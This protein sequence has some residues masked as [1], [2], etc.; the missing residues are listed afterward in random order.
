MK[1]IDTNQFVRNLKSFEATVVLFNAAGIIANYETGLSY[2]TINA[3]LTG[4]SLA[5][6]IDACHEADI[7]VIARTDFSKVRQAVYEA[8]PDWAFR[9]I[10]GGIINYMGVKTRDYNYTYHAFVQAQFPWV[11][12]SFA[13]LL[14]L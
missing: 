2:E 13:A 5:Q 7:R 11:L 14:C 3:F 9:Y 6:I 1:D 10:Q 4:G 12:D 8:H